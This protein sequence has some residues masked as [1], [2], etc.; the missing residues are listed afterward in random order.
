MKNKNSTATKTGAR[1]RRVLA[2][3]VALLALV[4][5]FSIPVGAQTYVDCI[6]QVE[7]IAEGEWSGSL[8]PSDGIVKLSPNYTVNKDYPTCPPSDCGVVLWVLTRD[9]GQ[10]APYVATSV[11][12][13]TY[14][15]K[16]VYLERVCRIDEWVLYAFS[17]SAEEWNVLCKGA[18]PYYM[19]WYISYPNGA[20]DL[21][22]N[23]WPQGVAYGLSPFDKFASSCASTLRSAIHV[24]SY[25]NGYND[26]YFDGENYGY[27]DGFQ[28]GKNEGL[29]EGN[30]IGY[31]DGYE[32]GKEVGYDEGYKQCV[33]DNPAVQGGIV[34][35]MFDGLWRSLSSAWETLS[36]MD[37]GI[38]LT[39][40]GVVGTL[41]LAGIV[42]LV[43]KMVK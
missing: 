26:G 18:P 24:E 11:P 1:A 2:F 6:D 14:T 36:S 30:A 33:T 22:Y 25:N 42:I 31:A 39:I 29:E 37:L 8:L 5:A 9:Y 34:G 10:Y 28:T 27:S 38:G 19:N 12:G 41:I 7:H 17:L 21:E 23:G 4:C 15:S 43:V 13:D 3:V 16:V 32:K 35:G 40:G 20:S